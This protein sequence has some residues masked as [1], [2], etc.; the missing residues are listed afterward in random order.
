[1]A[2]E[3]FQAADLYRSERRYTRKSSL[4]SRSRSEGELDGLTG[5]M[6][7]DI[8]ADGDIDSAVIFWMPSREVLEQI[9]DDSL[10]IVPMFMLATGCLPLPINGHYFSYLDDRAYEETSPRSSVSG[11]APRGTFTRY[12]ARALRDSPRGRAIKDDGNAIWTFELVEVLEHDVALLDMARP[13]KVDTMRIFALRRTRPN[14]DTMA[15]LAD[16]ENFTYLPADGQWVRLR[17]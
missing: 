17:L 8:D 7:C 9:A 6:R 5:S 13:F 11:P 15:K 14:R 12:E 16:Y 2:Q 1:M 4:D 3:G 10:T